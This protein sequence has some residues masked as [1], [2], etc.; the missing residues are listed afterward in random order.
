MKEFTGL[1]YA[2]FYK[3]RHTVLLM[4]HVLIP[5][6]G[7][8]V[9]LCY[10]KMSPHRWEDELSAYLMV[11]TTAFP[12]IISI[13]CAQSVSLEEDNHFSVFLG[14]PVRRG[15]AFL[16]KFFSLFFSGLFA[17][18]LAVGGFLTGYCLILKRCMLD[19][20][21]AG[22][23]IFVMWI[24]SAGVYVM[25]ILLNLWRPKSVS[26]CIGLVESIVSALML[27]GLGEGLWQ[28]FPCS[29]GGHWESF[30]MRYWLEG[31]WCVEKEFLFK[32]LIVNLL[33]TAAIAAAS[34]AGFYFYEGRR[35]HD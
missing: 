31:K 21:F 33:V 13:V 19:F 23:L 20:R 1:V 30:L 35:F 15:N 29:Y 7:I 12:F 16:A 6:F 25:H 3:M 10:Y 2:E 5:V 4:L 34:A 9:F 17:A 8:L 27:T 28:F 26:L 32:S 11:L 24:S 22:I 18:A 14:M